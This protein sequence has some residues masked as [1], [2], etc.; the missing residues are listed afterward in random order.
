MKF[1]LLIFFSTMAFAL[2]VGEE[3]ELTQYMNA[4]YSADFR[5]NTK[6][7]V[8]TLNKGTKGTVKE[9]R[10]FNS[11][12]SG[13]LLEVKDGALISQKV[14]V[15]YNEKSP[16]LALT[17]AAANPTTSVND[18]VGATA[19]QDVASVTTT[20]HCF[21]SKA[22]RDLTVNVQGSVCPNR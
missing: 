18:A 9:V 4:R 6:N 22:I 2:Q 11:G 14:W 1:L 16:S 19:I 3:V 7:V 5:K 13:F 8:G 10:K 12:N 20:D 17:D 15:Y 21:R